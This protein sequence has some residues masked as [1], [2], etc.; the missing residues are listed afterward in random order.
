[1]QA[2]VSRN[3]G[4]Y[5]SIEWRADPPV[6]TRH[7][8][9]LV[10]A[11]FFLLEDVTFLVRVADGWAVG[12]LVSAEDLGSAKGPKFAITDPA[13]YG[14]ENGRIE[15]LDTAGWLPFRF[16]RGRGFVSE[17]RV[18]TGAGAVLLGPGFSSLRDPTY[19]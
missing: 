5:G 8:P 10:Y 3:V 14:L 19:A 2:R 11:R 12:E 7:A 18:V 6:A 15:E 1:M 17:G 9:V 13:I 16:E 4:A